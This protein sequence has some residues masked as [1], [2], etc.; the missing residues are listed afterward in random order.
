MKITSYW[1]KSIPEQIQFFWSCLLREFITRIFTRWK[2]TKK[3]FELYQYCTFWMISFRSTDHD[4]H[5]K[6]P[7]AGQ[8]TLISYLP[9]HFL[10]TLKNNFTSIRTVNTVNLQI[11]REKLPLPWFRYNHQ[12]ISMLLSLSSLGRPPSHCATLDKDVP[13]V[14]PPLHHLRESNH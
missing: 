1:L 12:N 14:N 5:L 4:L 9:K 2:A 7:V 6:Y 8:I 3:T 11:Y 10:F 13:E